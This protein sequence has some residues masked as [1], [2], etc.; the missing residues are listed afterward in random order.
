MR[1]SQRQT[2]INDQIVEVYCRWLGSPW[3]RGIVETGNESSSHGDYQFAGGYDVAVWIRGE[4]LW[5]RNDRRLIRPQ[6]E[7]AN[8][9]T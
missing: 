8:V 2:F 7:Q 9:I 5:V 3:C 4:R 6:K 1:R